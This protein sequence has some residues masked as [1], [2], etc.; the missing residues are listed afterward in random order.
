MLGGAMRKQS[1]GAYAMYFQKFLEGYKAEGVPID[2]VTV[3]NETDAEQEGRMPA[4]LWAQEQEMEF[5]AKFLGPALRKAGLNTKIWV[6]DHNYSLWGRALDEL[7]DPTVYEAIDGIAWH[8]YVGEPSAMTRVHDAF[9]AKSAYWTEG[10]PDIAL[11]DYQT[12]WTKWADTF[13]GILNNWS[14]SITSWNVALDEKGS[15]NIGPFSC[16]GVVTIENGTHKVTRSGQYWAFAHYS[17]HVKRGAKVISSGGATEV[18]KGSPSHVAFRNPDGGYALVVANPGA[19]RSI[20]MQVGGN[21]LEFKAR[22]DSVH[23]L[24]WA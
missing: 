10:G 14:R 9:P 1:F 23:T 20:K 6:L 7:S 3:Q 24:E 17:R 18:A 12:D 15:P 21:C 16:G 5:A 19:E 11:P 22:A 2:A 8:G 13:N 4:C